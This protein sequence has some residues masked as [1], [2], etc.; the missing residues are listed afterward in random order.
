MFI[1]IKH[2]EYVLDKS[3]SLINHTQQLQLAVMLGQHDIVQLIYGLRQFYNREWLFELTM[4]G[5]PD[6]DMFQWLMDHH[7]S[8]STTYFERIGQIGDT[9]M[10]D[11]AI[12]YVQRSSNETKSLDERVSLMFKQAI[13]FN[14]TQLSLTC[15]T[16]IDVMINNAPSLIH[17]HD[18]LLLAV[19]LNRFDMVEYILQHYQH[20][21]WLFEMTLSG[22]PRYAM[23]KYLMENHITTDTRY[24]DRI[25]A[26]GDIDI[27]EMAIEYVSH[28]QLLAAAVSI[29]ECVH[30]MMRRAIKDNQTHLVRHMMTDHPTLISPFSCRQYAIECGNTEQIDIF[31]EM[32]P[33]S[34]DLNIYTQK[35]SSL[36]EIDTMYIILKK[37]LIGNM[38][39]IALL[40]CILKHFDQKDLAGIKSIILPVFTMD[41]VKEEDDVMLQ[42]LLDIGA[43][44][45]VN[46]TVTSCAHY[47]SNTIIQ[48]IFKRY[49]EQQAINK[50]KAIRGLPKKY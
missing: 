4:A 11:M 21:Q 20:R 5:R 9:R 32:V 50:K 30:Q 33:V 16:I 3:P 22:R 1:D 39:G 48:S 15:T 24:W 17:H 19:T 26:S 31:L 18:Q 14:Q 23:I 36:Y 34:I 6:Y 38:N 35:S 37:V 27:A 42:H 49:K 44:F 47:M 29:H 28:P 43:T 41:L 40:D 46:H 12:E 45:Q 10:A 25:G 2:L 7:T 13:K 8:K